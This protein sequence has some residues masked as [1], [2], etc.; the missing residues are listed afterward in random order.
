[1]LEAAQQALFKLGAEDPAS[2]RVV[3]IGAAGAIGAAY[4]RLLAQAS[5]NLVLVSPD[6]QKLAELQRSIQEQTPGAEIVVAA[7]PG[8]SLENCDLIVIAA[9]VAGQSVLEIARC[10]PGAVICDLACPPAIYP[11]EAALRPDVLVI[12]SA[13][14]R[15]FGKRITDEDIAVKRTLAEKLRHNPVYCESIKQEAAQKLAQIRV[16][17]LPRAGAWQQWG[18]PLAG[19]AG[20]VGLIGLLIRLNRR[21]R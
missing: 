9:S 18:L 16:K 6:L 17:R 12:E 15:S 10:K 21:R 5:K 11:A 14:L 13:D 1:M 4:A 19:L 2:I 20:L 8:K 3:L 7:Q